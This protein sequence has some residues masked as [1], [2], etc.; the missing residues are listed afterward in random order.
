[1][2]CV[3]EYDLYCVLVTT[4]SN[5]LA[6]IPL[7]S[8]ASISRSLH[9]YR[10]IPFFPHLLPTGAKSINFGRSA[11]DSCRPLQRREEVTLPA[12]EP[13]TVSG[14]VTRVFQAMIGPAGGQRGYEATTG[15]IKKC[16]QHNPRGC[17]PAKEIFFFF[18]FFLLER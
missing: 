18:F 3:D 15:M 5:P 9:V 11:R 16:P 17:F 7:Y 10:V 12:W 6:E 2:C 4:F 1:M 13:R 14:T 8:V